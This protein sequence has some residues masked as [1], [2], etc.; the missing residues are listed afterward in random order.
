MH[1][2]APLHA[3]AAQVLLHTPQQV[4]TDAGRSHVEERQRQPR[5]VEHRR[6]ALQLQHP[7]AIPAIQQ[8]RRSVRHGRILLVC[9]QQPAERVSRRPK[10]VEHYP[11][12]AVLWRPRDHGQRSWWVVRGNA[13]EQQQRVYFVRRREHLPRVCG[14]WVRGQCELS[15]SHDEWELVVDPRPGAELQHHVQHVR[16]LTRIVGHH[17][18][19][20]W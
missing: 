19:G 13:N 2:S 10:S 16:I 9:Q 7:L 5:V 14:V 20:E 15:G 12:D 4:R 3:S 6:P 8:L 18:L 11:A 1:T 17:R